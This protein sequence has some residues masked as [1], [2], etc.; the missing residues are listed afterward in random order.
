MASG[1]S[2]L[3]LVGGEVYA[4]WEAI[5]RD[6]VD[7]ISRVMYAKAGNRADAE[8]LTT[9]VFLVALRPL[10][11][12]ASVPE[13]R[14]YLLAT[15]RTVLATHWRRV[16]GLEVTRLPERNCRSRKRT[17]RRCPPTRRAG[18]AAPWRRCPTATGASSKC[19]SWVPVH[20]RRRPP[21]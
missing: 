11:T 19:V 5:Y 20:S 4:G 15:A 18:P 6:N 1:T 14:A 9:E 17:P 2:R 12:S 13:V 7:R 3:R 10:R 16:L 21:N 8:D